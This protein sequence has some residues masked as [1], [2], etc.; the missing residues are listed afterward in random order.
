M[1]TPFIVIAPGPIY[2]QLDAN[3]KEVLASCPTELNQG[4]PLPNKERWLAAIRWLNAE[5]WGELVSDEW[6]CPFEVEAL[7]SELPPRAA[8]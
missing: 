8:A 6:V 4:F 3:R 2:V 7:L 1:K 5:G